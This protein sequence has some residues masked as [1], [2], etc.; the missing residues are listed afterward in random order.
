MKLDSLWGGKKME[1]V[2]I[3]ILDQF[4]GE[5]F[6]MIGVDSSMPMIE[7]YT[8][9]L[10]KDSNSSSVDLICG[11]IEDIQIKNASVVLI[12]LTLQFLEPK[13]R[14]DLI[15][16]IYTGMT[17]GGV[18]FLTEKTVHPIPRFDALEKKNY[19][20]FKL[21]NGYSELEISQKREALEKVLVPDTMDIHTQRLQKAG[22]QMVDVWLKWFNFSSIMAIK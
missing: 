16:K 13:K 12:N 3:Q 20:R 18:L 19:R 2:G 9:R 21:E 11:R 6:S 22:F 5:K 17:P 8:H 1:I 4:E 7:K 15:Q 14:D 10:K